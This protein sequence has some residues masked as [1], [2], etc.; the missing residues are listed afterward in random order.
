[1]DKRLAYFSNVAV[2]VASF[3]YSRSGFPVGKSPFD[4]INEIF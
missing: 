4:Y 2:D 1:M 3:S